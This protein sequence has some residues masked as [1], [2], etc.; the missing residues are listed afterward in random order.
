MGRLDKKERGPGARPTSDKEVSMARDETK[1]S[2]V[3]VQKSWT[4]TSKGTCCLQFTCFLDLVPLPTDHHPTLEQSKPCIHLN[5]KPGSRHCNIPTMFCSHTRG[6]SVPLTEDF[7]CN[8]VKASSVKHTDKPYPPAH[9]RFYLEIA[10]P[11]V[12]F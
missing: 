4:Y 9:D 11:R 7:P 10:R 8:R 3:G 1:K 2:R 5:V 6:L 12:T